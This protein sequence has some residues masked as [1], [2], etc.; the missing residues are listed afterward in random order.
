MPTN[1]NNNN[2]NNNKQEFKN[3]A[4][5]EVNGLYT[6]QHTQE[7][8]SVNKNSTTTRSAFNIPLSSVSPTGSPIATASGSNHTDASPLSSTQQTSFV[9]MNGLPFMFGINMLFPHLYQTGKNI[10]QPTQQ[11]KQ[12][13]SQFLMN[14]NG[15]IFVPPTLDNRTTS[16]ASSS[17][18]P[19]QSQLVTDKM[20]NRSSHN[21]IPTAG[22]AFTSFLSISNDKPLSLASPSSINMNLTTQYPL[23][24]MT[25]AANNPITSSASSMVHK[26]TISS[27]NNVNQRQASLIKKFKDAQSSIT[28]TTVSERTDEEM[29]DIG[30]KPAPIDDN[31]KDNGAKDANVSIQ[32]K[33]GEE[34]PNVNYKENKDDKDDPSRPVLESVARILLTN[35]IK[36]QLQTELLEF[37]DDVAT[38]ICTANA[39]LYYEKQFKEKK[40][41]ETQDLKIIEPTETAK[42]MADS[43]TDI[44]EGE[45]ELSR[46][47][48]DDNFSMDSLRKSIVDEWSEVKSDHAWRWDWLSLRLEQLEQELDKTKNELEETIE[49]KKELYKSIEKDFEKQGYV[50]SRLLGFEWKKP[51]LIPKH[52]RSTVFDQYPPQQRRA[53]INRHPVFSPS[54]EKVGTISPSKPVTIEELEHALMLFN[55]QAYIPSRKRR[56]HVS[57]LQVHIPSYQGS[58]ERPSKKKRSTHRI[59]STPSRKSRYSSRSTRAASPY[60][61]DNIVVPWS[62]LRSNFS[63][64]EIKIKEILTPQWRTER[65]EEYFA[66]IKESAKGEQILHEEKELSSE[67]DTSDEAYCT[68]HLPREMLER[69][70]YFTNSKPT[71]SRKKKKDGQN[72]EDDEIQ[73]GASKSLS[74]TPKVPERI[75]K[76]I[77]EVFTQYKERKEKETTANSMEKDST[78]TVN[79][80]NISAASLP[81]RKTNRGGKSNDFASRWKH[82][83]PETYISAPYPCPDDIR[84]NYEEMKQK[85]AEFEARMEQE[86]K[87]REEM[88]SKTYHRSHSRNYYA[89]DIYY[90]LDD[91]LPSDDEKEYTHFPQPVAQ[92][93]YHSYLFED[94]EDLSFLE[95]DNDYNDLDEM[96]DFDDDEF[97]LSYGRRHRSTPSSEKRRSKNRRRRGTHTPSSRTAP[98]REIQFFPYT[99][100]EGI[101]QCA[102]VS[103][104]K[105]V[106]RRVDTS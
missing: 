106:L 70:R 100:L 91:V 89:N 66:S 12:T 58:V 86:R 57:N 76:E 101:W 19:S 62:E 104:T 45:E 21:Q 78:N 24:S 30:T 8:Y 54:V 92:H 27:P 26:F 80:S 94:G 96:E 44:S 35:M 13:Q 32:S 102:S 20:D 39:I 82:I 93:G 18:S 72:E 81:T 37:I 75:K 83:N 97:V 5:R 95:D 67:E 15:S 85:C 28:A 46:T 53:D 98:T 88:Q 22:N 43:S 73:P 23:F 50:P 49:M 69:K 16:P 17:V 31:K 64:P 71:T 51:T 59:A 60:D 56:R 74:A 103:G 9:G 41:K 4:T 1:N 84:G 33:E 25:N 2:N 6:Q 3:E 79:T 65:E 48:Y 10:S 87:Q 61:L 99:P 38:D 77:H 42:N 36:E 29:N 52:V 14:G 7:Q 11:T 90:S 63:I 68:M 34:I 55:K 105:I 40:E 47:V